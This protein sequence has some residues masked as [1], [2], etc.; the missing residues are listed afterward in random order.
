[1]DHILHYSNKKQT[2]IYIIYLYKNMFKLDA[3]FFP[4]VLLLTQKHA[5]IISSSKLS[6]P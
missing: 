5:K 4:I 1:M 3:K 2:Q 6:A